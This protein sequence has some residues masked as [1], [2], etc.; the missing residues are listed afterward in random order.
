MDD[1]TLMTEPDG[2]ERTQMV[3]GVECPV[4]HESNAPGAV[5]CAECGFRLGTEAGETSEAAPG[6]ALVADGQ[7]YPLK[8]GE[9]VV[10]RLNAEVFLSDP[11]V[12]RKHAVVT[13]S[14]QGVTVRDEGSSNGTKV[15]GE[16]AET[17]IETPVPAGAE[18]RFGNVALTL[19]APEG[20][21]HLVPPAPPAPEPEEARP[22]VAV[23]TD[24]V[25]T[26]PLHEGAN[27]IGRR[28]G[29]DVVLA[30]PAVSGRHAVVTVRDD[31]AAIADS[32]S[33]NG[34][35]LDDRRLIPGADETLA[36]GGLVR[37]ASVTLNFE[38]IPA[39]SG[40]TVDAAESEEAAEAT[41]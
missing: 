6:W 1:R 41:E 15:A 13:V 32:G 30:D 12:S 5:W 17:G 18:V 7:H 26:Y 36:P 10:G 22:P 37:F 35:F 20:M 16:T 23:L 4:C 21:E 9:N 8:A 38:R 33:T 29:N 3:G 27:T 39:A 19:S 11:S 40:L 14:E 31:A 25:N 34:T 2:A 24:G 28:A